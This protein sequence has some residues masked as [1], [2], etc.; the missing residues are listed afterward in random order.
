VAH[1]RKSLNDEGE[2]GSKEEEEESSDAFDGELLLLLMAKMG[3]LPLL[4]SFGEVAG[5]GDRCCSWLSTPEEEEDA[6]TGRASTVLEKGKRAGVG[7]RW[8]SRK[9][10]RRRRRV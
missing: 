6:A 5:V 10:G 3:C 4:L 7:L 2:Q 9:R 1:N 8:L